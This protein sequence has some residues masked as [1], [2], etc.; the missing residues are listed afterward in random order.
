MKR[1][2]LPGDV[3]TPIYGAVDR[4]TLDEDDPRRRTRLH[5]WIHDHWRRL[6]G[7]LLIAGVVG[8]FYI[9]ARYG[10]VYAG[11]VFWGTLGTIPGALAAIAIRWRGWK[12]PGML[13]DV[14]HPD[15]ERVDWVRLNRD[16]AA[17][18]KFVGG[19]PKE[20]RTSNGNPVYKVR[21]WIP[22]DREDVRVDLYP[23]REID[24]KQRV[25]GP[26]IVCPPD[27]MPEIGEMETMHPQ[28]RREQWMEVE[29]AVRYI[30]RFRHQAENMINKQAYKRVYAVTKA[31]SELRGPSSK[32]FNQL[33]RVEV[34][35]LAQEFARQLPWTDVEAADADEDRA[36]VDA[37]Q[38]MESLQPAS[39]N[40][41]VEN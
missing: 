5:W 10:E 11:Y 22:Q 8:S 29:N 38:E 15:G 4:V 26:A 18:V 21:R 16:M 13:L 6:Y 19:K 30:E 28:R 17:Q 36:P 25:D 41:E 40:G 2:D 35:D 1:P 14:E 20:K 9:K 24:A 31:M 32:H 27:A 7:L 34:G 23:N 39:G 3:R 12:P 37:E 33:E